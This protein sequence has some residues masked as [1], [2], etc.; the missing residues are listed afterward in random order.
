MA[1]KNYTPHTINIYKESDVEYD[2]T[3]RKFFVKP[4][5]TACKT[6]PSKG[7]ANAKIR[8]VADDAIDGI[9][10]FRP[11]VEAADTLPENGKFIV[12]ALYVQACKILGQDTAHLFT[13]SQPVY[14]DPDNPRPVGCLGL[15]R[16]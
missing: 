14:T 4:G 1:L 5:A 6:I 11:T 15:N 2:S 12:S 3:H 13:V 10:T 8:Y 9:P 16:N 7:I